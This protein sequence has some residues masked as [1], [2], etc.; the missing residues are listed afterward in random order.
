MK[1]S[2]VIFILFV[3]LSLC[4]SCE[5]KE[6]TA[7][8]ESLKYIYKYFINAEI[9]QCKLKNAIV[10][11]ASLNACDAPAI[12]YSYNGIITGECNFTWEQLIKFANNLL[13]VM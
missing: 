8:L 4:F 12:I 2:F 13:I 6:E 7:N 11:C 9:D 10:F 3:I 5:K 1:R